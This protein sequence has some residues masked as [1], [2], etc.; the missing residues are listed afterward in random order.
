MKNLV[1]QNQKSLKSETKDQAKNLV[2][3][4][5]YLIFHG[6]ISCQMIRV[7]L[8]EKL[9]IFTDIIDLGLNILMPEKSVRVYPTD[10]PWM[11]AE[12]KSL[13]QKRQKAFNSGHLIEFKKLRN[14]V[15]HERKRCRQIYYVNKIHNLH[16]TKPRN[17]WNEIKQLF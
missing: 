3:D 14:K 1:N 5:I 10:R 13:I 9:T 11:N 2:L 12:I 16:N 7:V 17:W 8:E 15:N 6:P 4:G